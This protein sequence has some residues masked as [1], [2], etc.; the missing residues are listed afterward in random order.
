MVAGSRLI[1][2]TDCDDSNAYWRIQ[3]P[4][5]DLD[6]TVEGQKLYFITGGSIDSSLSY[7]VG[8]NPN[9]IAL[10]PGSTVSVRSGTVNGFA[11]L[12]AV[13]FYM[14]ATSDGEA[15]LFGSK[16]IR[17]LTAGSQL[18]CL[19]PQNGGTPSNGESIVYG[20]DGQCESTGITV[21]E[22]RNQF[23]FDCIGDPPAAPPTMPPPNAPTTHVLLDTGN[24]FCEAIGLMSITDETECFDA[25]R[26]LISPTVN[27]QVLTNG[28]VNL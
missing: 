27:T 15:L 7:T 22:R 12:Y 13:T 26:S 20:A 4:V 11:E 6:H 23:M 3:G 28:N 5:D 18:N 19:V 1:Y 25:A 24:S 10:Q 16:L 2:S 8:E 9:D 21:E 17:Q 14:F